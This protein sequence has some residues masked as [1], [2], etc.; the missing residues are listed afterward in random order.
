MAT[1]TWLDV[2]PWR[3]V[4]APLCNAPGERSPEALRAV[5]AQ[6]QVERAPRYASRGGL[7]YC[8]IFAWDVS[9][10]L[11]AEIPHWLDNPRRE[12]TANLTLGWLEAAP[13]WHE[14]TEDVARANADRGA[15]SVAIWRNPT[16]R[17]G[18]IAILVPSVFG[19]TM[20][21]QAGRSNFSAGPLRSGFGNVAPIRFFAHE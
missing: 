18:H 8:N 3:P 9:T 19:S 7:T 6:F 13:D 17:S 12:L 14:V 1:P 21:A 2:Q 5:V 4:R 16:G 15:P 20:I 10:A 11:H